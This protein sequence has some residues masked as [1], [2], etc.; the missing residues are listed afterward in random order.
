MRDRDPGK[1]GSLGSVE[2]NKKDYRN[3]QP[4]QLHLL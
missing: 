4:V 2:I 3:L 1:G